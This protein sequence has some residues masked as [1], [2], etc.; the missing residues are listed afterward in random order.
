MDTILCGC[1]YLLPPVNQWDNPIRKYLPQVDLKSHTAIIGSTSRTSLTQTFVNPSDK[2]IDEIRYAFPL[3]DGVSVVEFTCTIGE[4]VI[5]GVVKAKDKAKQ[6]YKEAKEQGHTVALME[7]SFDASDVF[8]TTIGN[9]PAS[10][11]LVVDIVY[12]GELKHDA[13]VDGLRF[14]IPTTIAPRYGDSSDTLGTT[15]VGKE[16]MSFTVDIQLE[17]SAVKA[18]QSP[19]HKIAVNIGTISTNLNADPSLSRASASLTQGTTSLDGDFILQVVATRLDEPTALLET[20]PT[21]P[22]Q[23]ALMTTLVPKFD[24]ALEKPEIVF[25]CD[26]SGSMYKSITPL[27]QALQVFL[28]SLPVGVKF[29]I[30]SFGSSFSFLWSKS[31]TYDQAS[32]DEASK[33]ISTFASNMGGTEMFKPVEQTFKQRFKDMNLEVFLLTDGEIWDQEKLFDMI[34]TQVAKSKGAIRVFS[35]GIGSGV[36][37]ASSSLVE[38]I[39]R[40]GNGFAQMVSVDEKLD[41]KIVRML[42]ASLFPHVNDYS[43]EIKYGAAEP[44]AYNEKDKDGDDFVLVEKLADSLNISL[45]VDEKDYKKDHAEKRLISLFDRNHKSDDETKTTNESKFDHLPE[46]TVPRYL[47]APSKIPGLFPYNRTTVYV[48]LSDSTPHR[49]PTSVILRGT[50]TQG[51]LALEIPISV[52]PD[53]GTTLHQLAAR[54]EVKDL[55]EGRGWLS[56]AKDDRGAL[57]KTKFPGR[58]EDMVEREAV[59]LGVEYQIVGKWTSFIAVDSEG[60]TVDAKESI[61]VNSEGGHSNPY[62]MAKS[63]KKSARPM[64]AFFSRSGGGGPAHLMAAPRPCAAPPPAPASY[65]FSAA[66]AGGAP[67]PPPV[68]ASRSRSSTAGSA[69]GTLQSTASQNIDALLERGEKMDQL[70]E[71]TDRLAGSA[72]EFRRQ[73]AQLAA[74]SNAQNSSLFGGGFGFLGRRKSAKTKKAAVADTAQLDDDEAVA[75]ES[76]VITPAFTR[77]GPDSLPAVSANPLADLTSLQAFDGSWSWSAALEAVLGIS[78]AD[79]ASKVVVSDAVRQSASFQTVLATSCVVA[80]FKNKLAQDAEAWE[81]MVD[82]AED[83]VKAQGGAEVRKA[84]EALF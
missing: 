50:C 46:V 47:Q 9:V 6:E 17:G 35:L 66:P 18:V 12:L 21:L 36:D 62:P 78:A 5:K 69:K 28:K 49:I 51:P 61:H 48:L 79:A 84:A 39:A 11:N 55:E 37:G 81:M 42:K 30:C 73:A 38:G 7:Q 53:K 29:N 45:D 27:I 68:A 10:A 74:E 41:K 83:W 72:S 3:Y 40:A 4:R 2:P 43:L 26:R 24:L 75:E 25:I 31:R 80:F 19:S 76:A 22:N 57:F 33:H 60:P 8:T 67:P 34:N 77:G 63:L 58:Y 70:Q 82:K 64:Q 1:Y 54:Q 52:I 14:T 59:R 65:A 56:F 20:H 15:R 23:R 44:P 71:S 13:Q 32:L 16:S